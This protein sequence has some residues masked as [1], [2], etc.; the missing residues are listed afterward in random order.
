MTR[1]NKI[2]QDETRESK[3]SK[4][5]TKRDK[6]S[7]GNARQTQKRWDNTEKNID[8]DWF[9]LGRTSRPG[10]K[11]RKTNE[12]KRRQGKTRQDKPRDKTRYC[13]TT[14][15]KK[16]SE[17]LASKAGEDKTRV[18]MT[19]QIEKCVGKEDSLAGHN[20]F[21][22]RQNLKAYWDMWW[23]ETCSSYICYCCN[24]CL[25]DTLESSC[26]PECHQQILKIAPFHT[27]AENKS[28]LEKLLMISL[29]GCDSIRRKTI[30]F[31]SVLFVATLNC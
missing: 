6:T 5:K 25:R 17:E 12:V 10:S 3:T 15:N 26:G 28:S 19:R 29:Q 27:G 23:F 2:R 4:A 21:A 9:T 16:T 13:P 1:Q 31:M 7:Q 8:G 20:E 11:Q 22:K 14:N 18:D 30:S 24:F